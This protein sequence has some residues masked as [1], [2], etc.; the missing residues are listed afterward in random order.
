MRFVKR[1]KILYFLYHTIFSYPAPTTLNYWWNMG[2]L[3]LLCLLVQI[4]TGIFLAMHY[5]P[6]AEEAFNSVE[7][8]MR[9]VNQG[10]LIRYIHANGASMFFLVVYLHLF[11]GLFH[12]S[13]YHPRELL[14]I[15][16]VIILLIMILTAFMGYVLPWGQ[17]SFWAATV[18]TTLVSA[19]PYVGQNIVYWL[20]GGFS[21]DHATLNRFFSLH[22]L[23]PFVLL[24]LVMLHVLLLHEAKS[25]NPNVSIV[26]LDH[27]PMSPYYTIKDIFGIIIFFFIF[28]YFVFFQ[29]NYLG[30][31]DNYI[32]A[33][34]MVTPTHIVP[35]W[36]FLPFYAILRSVPNKLG[37]VIL[38][39][40]AIIVLVI[41]PF[42]A[43]GEVRDVRH[44]PIESTLFTFFV[45]TT[46]FL[47][48][49]GGKSIETPFLEIGK[50]ATLYYFAF[51]IVG[52]PLAIKIEKEL[53]N[54]DYN[55]ISGIIKG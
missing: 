5:I 15:V 11:R 16:G 45:V 32:E 29:P 49:V 21:V 43:R 8:I 33:N 2:S 30:H 31:P 55:P 42:Y 26:S 13:Y 9:D 3:A 50:G 7:H 35:E 51:L 52:L 23:F 1:N 25:N 38:L 14:W 54:S 53:H 19:I 46:I 36:Y 47:G 37:G 6:S 44:K 40:G 12:G 10:W 4:I 28:S 24:G 20:W 41:L 34:P 27:I 39:L 17:M 22:Y 48:W 18:I